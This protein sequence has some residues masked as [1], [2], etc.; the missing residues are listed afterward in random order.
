[1]SKR[2]ADARLPLVDFCVPLSC[3]VVGWH[4]FDCG[5]KLRAKP[6]TRSCSAKKR[7]F[8]YRKPRAVPFAMTPSL[9]RD[10]VD[11]V[12]VTSKELAISA[13]S[14]S[15]PT[16]NLCLPPPVAALA[17]GQNF[18]GARPQLRN[19]ATVELCTAQ[20]ASCCQFLRMNLKQ[21][22]KRQSIS[23]RLAGRRNCLGRYR[24]LFWHY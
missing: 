22:Y 4:T 20:T 8:S 1:M 18:A 13:L 15:Q 17:A 23:S 12:W 6:G 14:L 16:C 2:F 11:H 3:C 5:T 19:F 10:Y 21:S 7:I 24:T 9:T